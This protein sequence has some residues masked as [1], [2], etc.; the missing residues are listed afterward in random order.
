MARAA[1][2]L[3]IRRRVAVLRPS[4]TTTGR[5]DSRRRAQ[6]AVDEERRDVLSSVPTTSS[7]ASNT[8]KASP[9]VG[10]GETRN[11]QPDRHNAK[12]AMKID[13]RFQ[14]RICGHKAANRVERPPVVATRT[15]A[16][17][18][19]ATP[20]SRAHPRRTTLPRSRE[21]P[22]QPT[23]S[24]LVPTMPRCRR[25]PLVLRNLRG[26]LRL[27]GSQGVDAMAVHRKETMRE[28]EAVVALEPVTL[29]LV[30][31]PVLGPIDDRSA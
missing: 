6:R 5:R 9:E 23:R 10:D 11:Q 14:A 15:A 1:A 22:L 2:A 30:V 24:Y 29:D 7:A 31:R 21:A 26:V 28:P 18:S 16:S 13:R 25:A 3:S 20:L 27:P 12:N 4:D 8:P 19:A 17:V